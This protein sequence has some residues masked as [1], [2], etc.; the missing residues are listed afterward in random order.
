MGEAIGVAADGIDAGSLRLVG[1]VTAALGP[2]DYNFPST[3]WFG[4][5]VVYMALEEPAPF[6]ELAK[7]LWASAPDYPP[8]EGQCAQKTFGDG[9]D[10]E[11]LRAAEAVVSADAQ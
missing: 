5:Q 11:A 7:R 8:Y 10:V 4:E 9:T 6:I 2:F 1:D 3:G